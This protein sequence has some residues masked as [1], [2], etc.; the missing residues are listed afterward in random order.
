LIGLTVSSLSDAAFIISLL[1]LAA[2]SVGVVV[3]RKALHMVSWLVVASLG[4]AS[5]LAL[6]GYGY[7]SVFHIVV[8]IG[9]AIT[10]IAMV[11]LMLGCDVEPRAWRPGKL[12][13]SVFAA[14]VLQTPVLLYKPAYLKMEGLELRKAAQPLLQCWLC[15]VLVV[16]TV[17]TVVIEAVAIARSRGGSERP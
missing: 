9:T 14:A 4:V 3:A 13:L 11:I 15:T 17:A 2:G 1:A 16:V 10:L 8:Y 5:L 12:L 6:S 7:I